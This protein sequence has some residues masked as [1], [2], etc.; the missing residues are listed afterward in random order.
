[1]LRSLLMAFIDNVFYGGTCLV[2]NQTKRLCDSRRCC[3]IE[4]FKCC[5]SS[6]DKRKVCVS[7]ELSN[8]LM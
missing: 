3:E 5:K 8:V 4:N 1:M 7:L 6:L 2:K